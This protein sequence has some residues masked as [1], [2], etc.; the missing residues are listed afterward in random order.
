[1]VSS[2]LDRCQASKALVT[3][4]IYLILLQ[5]LKNWPEATRPSGMNTYSRME[6]RAQPLCLP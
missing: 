5:K 2:P 1:M 6:A 4:D 3:Q